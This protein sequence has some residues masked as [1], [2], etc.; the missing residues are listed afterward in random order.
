MSPR[1]ALLALLPA[2]LVISGIRASAQAQITKGQA[3]YIYVDAASGSDGN[4]GSKTSPLKTI[5]AAVDRADNNNINN[6]ATQIIVNSGVYRESVNIGTYRSTQATVTIQAA[7]T[8]GAIIDGADVLDN[9]SLTSSGIYTHGWT[10]NL[11]TCDIPA[12]W[13]GNIPAIARRTEMLFVNGVPLTQVMDRS[14]LRP[15]T[16]FVSESSSLIYMDPPSG[17]KVSSATIEAAIR[18][19]TLNIAGRDNIVLRG[20]VFRHAASCI[21]TPSVVVNSSSNILFDS[22]QAMWNNWAGIGVFGT[23]NVTIQNS[24]AS[25]NG[26]VG[27]M[28]ANDQYVLFNYNESDYNNWRGAQGALYDW[29]MGGAKF[30]YMRSTTVQNHYSYHNQA[31]GL[32]ID[33]DNKD[34]TI[35]H[36]TLSGNTMAALQLE[37]DEGPITLENSNLCRSGA[38]VNILNVE[39]LTIKNNNFY[40]NSGTGIF[41]PAEIFVAG[42]AGGHPLYD[43]LTGQYYNLMTKGTVLSGNT[44]EDAGSGQY[45]FGTYLA[46]GDWSQ[47]A[48]TLNASNNRWYDPD[49]MSDF[50]IPGSKAVTLAE[51]QSATGTDYSSRWGK[52]SMSPAGACAIP[53]TTFPDFAVSLNRPGY[54]MTSGAA[55]GLVSVVSYNYRTVNIW[56][57]GLPNGVS[58][59]LSTRH[60][61]SGLVTIEFRASRTA[62]WRTVPVTL[63]AVSGNR[64]HSVTFNL[65]VTPS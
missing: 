19:L 60:L 42:Y 20:L 7:A 15:G 4:S 46:G 43:W 39:N 17:V 21:N 27:F 25:Y 33:T 40:N 28:S 62:A 41:D 18:P 35:N 6:I 44:F 56:F 47:F 31:Q 30:M 37:A 24:V 23:N 38:G 52:A 12:G 32:W 29:G 1:K 16:F 3:T 63:W 58:A 36:V 9:W 50:K 59:S 11:G 22:D 34:V 64:V 65:S 14:Q 53:S 57:T 8:G 54:S 48:T 10:A 61:T 55:T 51:W 5:Q 45:V 49:T 2:I 26:G 13:P